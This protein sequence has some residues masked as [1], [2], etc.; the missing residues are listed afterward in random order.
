[1]SEQSVWERLT[2]WLLP[3]AGEKREQQLARIH[4]L[5]RALSREPGSAA[6]YI[7]RG[8]VYL[9]A[10]DSQA[11]AADFRQALALAETQFKTDTWGVVAQA[12]RDRALQGLQQA[13]K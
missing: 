2:A 1:M 10:G 9:E 8:E 11:A 7:S 5:T 12:V 13:R 3:T 4:Q 6:S